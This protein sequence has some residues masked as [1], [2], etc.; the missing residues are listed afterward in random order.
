LERLPAVD[1]AEMTTLC[2]LV[3]RT[4]F[5][6][7]LLLSI[8]TN[9]IAERPNVLLI[10]ADDLGWGDLSCYPQDPA[11]PDSPI[12]TPQLDAV[13]ASGVRFT[14]AY[15]QSMCSP[16]RAA[17]LT[18]RFPQRFGFCDNS[19]A[20]VGLPRSEKN[21]AE[22]LRDNGYITACIGKWH[23]GH[24][25]GYRPLERGFDRFFGFLGASHDY[26]KPSFGTDTDGAS[27]EGAFVYD[28]DRPVTKMGHLTDELTDQAI[29]F[30]QTARQS[31][32][33][34]F[35]YLPYNAPHGPLQPR[36]DLL[37]E[38]QRRPANEPS[39][40][41]T[42]A[43]I[44]GLDQGVGRLLRELF[45]SGLDDNTMIVFASDN[46]GNEY[47]TVS[48][49]IRSVG[50]NGGLR[51]TKFTTW[52]GGIRVPLIIKWPGHFPAGKTYTDIVNLVDLYATIA[53]AASAKIDPNQ[54]LDGVDLSPFVTGQSA[55]SP[56]DVV[57][58]RNGRRDS[59]WAVRKGD[60]KLV[61]DYPYKDPRDKQSRKQ[62]VG[63]YDL[64]AEV[65]NERDNLIHQ[66]PDVVKELRQ[67]HE[68]FTA[69]CPPPLSTEAS[70]RADA[71]PVL[72]K[73]S[74]AV[75]FTDH[76]VLQRDKPVPVWGNGVPNQEYSI[77]FKRQTKQARVS[78]D[79]R[80]QVMLEPMPASNEP[81]ELR[82]R[83]LE[84]EEEVV[85]RDVLVGDVWLAGGQSNMGSRMK[86][87]LDSVAAEIPKANYPSFRVFTVPQRKLPN[88]PIPQT[89]WQPIR[90]DTVPDISAT[91][92]FFGRDLHRNL[93][94][95]IGIV[96]CAWGGTFA[97]NWI[98]RALLA[99][100]SETAPI[101]ERYDAIVEAY[102]GDVNYQTQLA[103]WRESLEAW[104]SKR[105]SEGKAGPREKEP[106]GPEHF[107]RPSGL[108]ETM[109][110]TTPPFGFKGVV[111]YQGESNVADG[112]SYQ[113]RYLLP[114][115]VENWRRDLGQELPFL[116][117][118]LPVIK[119]Q[120]EDEWAEM[121][122]SQSIACR[123]TPGCELAIVLEYGEYNKLHPAMKEGVGARLAL[124]A[125]GAVYGE[126]VVHHGP[127]LRSYRIEG[128]RMVLEFDSGGSGLVANGELTDF[129]IS[130]ASGQFVP[131]KAK[132]VDQT[133]H[134]WA[135]EMDHPF[136]VRYGW[137]NFFVPSLFN[138]EGL[139]AEPFRTDT[140][141]LK[142]QK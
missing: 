100:H 79:G 124:L 138:L 131:A 78:G 11:N 141:Q 30:I 1:G 64:R 76:M 59:Q 49:E 112:R 65:P 19:G 87:Y 43:L 129:M 46:G 99:S 91:A 39:R 104:K 136:A 97:E 111:F 70:E 82:L 61:N 139:P 119:G 125:R 102:N 4:F 140:F 51:G 55:G 41:L 67:L 126:D 77:T 29:R 28:Q 17:V 33:P 26:F 122:E 121:R 12:H 21:L 38:Q 54:E 31:E 96:V 58:S 35:L 14:Q 108:Y 134:V 34:F 36:V 92:Y 81:H 120:H 15:S 42:R 62:I 83:T 106:M 45:L 130:D 128:N 93:G 142:T 24:L 32:K 22:L 8:S 60:W 5:I 94:V 71:I 18:G 109:F 116:V 13:A 86:E 133:V 69:T 25:P 105:R 9:A 114:M 84:G 57:L 3:V 127:S 103:V 50:H 115:L 20:H 7:G 80:W 68:S 48:G 47:E 44:D 101:V 75:I 52:E 107:Q 117:V 2:G 10:L 89:V 85:I 56:H 16:A 110:K 40:T 118:Q 72:A 137:K 66:F 95:P 74:L 90:S 135:D 132:I 113:Y 53:S 73:P 98:D 37:D 63:L 6:L 23:V 88:E 27:Y 123:Q